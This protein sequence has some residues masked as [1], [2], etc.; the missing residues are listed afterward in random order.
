MGCVKKDDD[1]KAKIKEQAQR[2]QDLGDD[3][4]NANELLT[5][6][7]EKAKEQAAT[8]GRLRAACAFGDGD[9]EGPEFLRE[10]AT[11]ISTSGW[12]ESAKALRAKAD[13]EEAALGEKTC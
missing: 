6:A 1:D 11:A 9:S 3:L 10:V 12:I 7:E 8:I 4:D 13:V 2:I 5:I